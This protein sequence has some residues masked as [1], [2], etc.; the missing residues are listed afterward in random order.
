MIHGS[1]KGRFSMQI[2][3]KEKKFPDRGDEVKKSGIN[4]QTAFYSSMLASMYI[5]NLLYSFNIFCGMFSAIDSL[6]K[7]S[8]LRKEN[9]RNSSQH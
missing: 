5:V 1:R 9:G 2:D 3:R 6:N 4:C 7:N 8:C